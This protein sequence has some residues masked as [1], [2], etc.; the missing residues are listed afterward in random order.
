MDD[1]SDKRIGWIGENFTEQRPNCIL[2][3]AIH[4]ILVTL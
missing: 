4:L 1:I 3:I 2:I